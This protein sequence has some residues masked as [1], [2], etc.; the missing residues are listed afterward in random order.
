MYYTIDG[1]NTDITD[2]ICPM[3]IERTQKGSLD[4]EP[5]LQT[6]DGR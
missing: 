1:M 4:E 6:A 3:A 2:D 5:H